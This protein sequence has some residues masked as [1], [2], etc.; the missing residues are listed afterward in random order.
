MM[1]AVR[2]KIQLKNAIDEELVNRGLLAPNLLRQ[3]EIEGLVNTG[4]VG[5]VI[6]QQVVEDLGLR[7][8][9]Q[10]I[11][12]YTNGSEESIGFTGPVIVTWENLETLDEAL[13]VGNEVLIGQVILEKLDLLVDCKNQRLIPNPEHPDYPVAMIKI[14]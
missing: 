4:A 8:R 9:G 10:R 12:Q 2:A 13:V 5:L 1:G 7:I 6:P 14:A 3:I 11:A